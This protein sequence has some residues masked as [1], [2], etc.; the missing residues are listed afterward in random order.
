MLKCLNGKLLKCLKSQNHRMVVISFHYW[1]GP[2]GVFLSQIPAQARPPRTTYQRTHPNVFWIS[3]RTDT[4]SSLSN[5]WHTWMG[6][7]LVTVMEKQSFLIFKWSFLSQFLTTGSGPCSVLFAIAP[8]HT[9]RFLYTFDENSSEYP[10]FQTELSQLSQA[11][12]WEILQ[13]LDLFCSPMLYVWAH[14][15]WVAG[16]DLDLL[17]TLKEVG[18]KW[19]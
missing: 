16:K 18:G 12:L 7:C 15:S 2:L 10:L 9:F 11:Y 17:A 3:S 8:H 14:H 1:K 19:E 5:Q 13:C 4:T 6:Q